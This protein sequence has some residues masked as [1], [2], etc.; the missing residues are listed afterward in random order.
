MLNATRLQ[1]MNHFAYLQQFMASPRTVGTLAP[2]SPWLCQAM[3]NQVEW[4]RALSIAELGAADGVLTKRILGR[5]RADA[6]L[7]AFEINRISCIGYGDRR[8]AA[9]GDGPFGDPNG[10]GLR[11]GV[12]LPAAAVD[13][14]QD[15]RAHSSAG[16]A[17]AAGAQ[18]HAGAVPIQ[19][20]V[21][22]I[23]VPLF[24]LEAPAGG[25]Q[26]P[27]GAGVCLYAT[28]TTAF[29]PSPPRLRHTA[30]GVPGAANPSRRTAL[31][32]CR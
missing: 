9:T 18:R 26:F 4:T 28:L 14:G 20:P 1:L 15:Q 13:S 8:S 17:A 5:M 16:P 11:R 27:A 22:K 19:P 23:A 7:E 10:H 32:I 31:P 6:G 2:S 3:L 25:A 21:G 30:A 29:S 12:F 24:S